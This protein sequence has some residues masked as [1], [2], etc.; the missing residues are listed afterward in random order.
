MILIIQICS[1]GSDIEARDIDGNTPLIIASSNGHQ[2]V[3]KVLLKNG[4]NI[5]E[6]N[7]SDRT[8]LHAAVYNNKLDALKVWFSMAINLKTCN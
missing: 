3:I 4:A 1:R 2:R 8:V 7:K 5:Q 6:I